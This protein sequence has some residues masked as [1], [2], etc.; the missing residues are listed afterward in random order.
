MIC[1]YRRIV[2]R[3]PMDFGT[4]EFDR[5]TEEYPACYKEE[6]PYYG[7]DMHDEWCNRTKNETMKARAK[8]KR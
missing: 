8:A 3:K 2:N 4:I 7:R 1:P 6:C 5:Y